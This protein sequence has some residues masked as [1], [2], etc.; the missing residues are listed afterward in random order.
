MLTFY[1]NWQSFLKVN[2][3]PA[4]LVSCSRWAEPLLDRPAATG[5]S[6]ISLMDSK[7]RRNLWVEQSCHKSSYSKRMWTPGRVANPQVGTGIPHILHATVLSPWWIW[8]MYS[9]H[10]TLQSSLFFPTTLHQEFPKPE[11]E[12]LIPGNERLSRFGPAPWAELGNQQ[13]SDV[14]VL[15][16]LKY[17]HTLKRWAATYW[18]K[19]AVFMVSP[20]Q[21]GQLCLHSQITRT[22]RMRWFSC[23][24]IWKKGTTS[25][26]INL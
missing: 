14:D 8:R 23:W 9:V 16:W 20:A 4:H 21:S 26:C 10:H 24:W 6:L 17:D 13:G 3:V 19:W 2:R 18:I 1:S 7:V 12:K 5:H 25:N 15:V 11:M 22:Q